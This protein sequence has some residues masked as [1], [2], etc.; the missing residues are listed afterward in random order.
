MGEVKVLGI[1]LDQIR[2]TSKNLS[3][4]ITV[5]TEA[6]YQRAKGLIEG[7]DGLG[8]LPLDYRTAVNR[9]LASVRPR[10]AVF[11]ETEIWPNMITEL[12]RQTIPIFLA[13]G[14]L[15]EKAFRRYR[16][17][18]TGLQGI[19]ACYR[20]MMVQSRA[21]QERFVSLG[22]DASIIRIVGNLKFD[23]PITILPSEE[24]K[25]LRKGLPFPKDCRILIAG[26]TRNGEEPIV[27]DVYKRLL[28]EFPRL[29]VILVPRHL[30]KMTDLCTL[31]DERG[32][33]CCLYSQ[34]PGNEKD[35]DALIIDRMGLLNDL[36]SI[37]DIAFVGGTLV[38]IGGQNILEP[39][40]AGIPVL[41]GRSI[42]NVR[43]SA[44]YILE[45][46]H[47]AMI[48]DGDDMYEKLS[49]FLKGGITFDRKSAETHRPTRALQTAAVILESIQAHAKTLAQ[50]SS[51]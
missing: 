20:T 19:F 45:G 51:R 39:V 38:D 14:R 50:D 10:S 5:M 31:A 12:N 4:Y 11:I 26:S 48:S 28:Q 34:L 6:G 18:R 46:N 22:A 17:V 35:L 49:L 21:D 40:W 16:W 23:A 32:L 2:K 8:F 13:N 29:R 27:L 37:S 42:Y 24:R 44:N 33:K 1:L 9:F 36:Y 7:G 15:S 3:V 41:F 47:G 43:D 25:S 30:D